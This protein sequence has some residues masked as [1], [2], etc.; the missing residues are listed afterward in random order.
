MVLLGAAAGRASVA[1]CAQVVGTHA[2]SLRLAGTRDDASSMLCAGLCGQFDVLIVCEV[3][4]YEARLEREWRS[5]PTW[6]LRVR[7]RPGRP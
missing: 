7:G 5:L 4:G 2:S 1:A 6:L 3:R